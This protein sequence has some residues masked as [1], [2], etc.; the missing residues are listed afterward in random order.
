MTVEP[1]STRANWIN[2][3]SLD[4]SYIAISLMVGH[5]T[6]VWRARGDPRLIHRLPDPMATD[7]QR[8]ARPDA[9]LCEARARACVSTYSRIF[10]SLPFRTV[11]SKTQSSLNG[12]FV[13]LIFPVATPMTRTRSL[14]ATNSGGSGYVVSTSS[15]AF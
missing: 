1:A 15:D 8:Y 12:L 7:G 2:S 10:V 14:C 4:W 5:S 3:N 13:A 6:S 11:M 9:S